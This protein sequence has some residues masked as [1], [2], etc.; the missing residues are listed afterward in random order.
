MGNCNIVSMCTDCKEPSLTCKGCEDEFCMNADEASY[1]NDSC[2]AFCSFDCFYDAGHDFCPMGNDTHCIDVGDVV[3]F[4][5]DV[6][7]TDD[8]CN[9]CD[10]RVALECACT[11]FA[12]E[13]CANNYER[14]CEAHHADN[15]SP[16]SKPAIQ[17]TSANA[18]TSN[19]HVN[20]VNGKEKCFCNDDEQKYGGHFPGGIHCRIGL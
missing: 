6:C 10:P 3:S 17:T 18:P 9:Q 2:G 8:C 13:E 11:G 7:L 5:C 16:T 1:C 4:E 19:P 14:Q 20:I 15:A 12:C